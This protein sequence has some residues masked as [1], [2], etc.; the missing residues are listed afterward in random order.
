MATAL[1]NLVGSALQPVLKLANATKITGKTPLGK[2]V[3]PVPQ[4]PHAAS[5]KQEVDS[6]LDTL[7]ANKHNW[8]QVDVS[9]RAEL[10]SACLKNVLALA[11]E[12]A[13]V[14]TVAKGSYEGG[15]G[16][17]M[18]TIL[19]IVTALLEYRET[20]KANGCKPPLKL[21]RRDDGQWVARVWPLNMVPV[22]FPNFVGEVWIQPG[23]EPTQGALY[24]AKQQGALGEG[25]VALVLG[26]GNQLPVVALDILH[27][28]LAEDHVVLCKMNPVNDYYGPLLK[29]AFLPLA[30]RGFLDFVYGGA[31]V[32]AY[33][34]QHPLV[35]SVH[36]TGSETTFNNIV[37]GTPEWSEADLNYHACNVASGLA[38][39]AGHN[40]I[41]A[42]VV[43]TDASWPQRRAFLQAV[44]RC[45]ADLQCRAPWYPGSAARLAEFKRQFPQAQSL[46]ITVPSAD[47]PPGHV[48]AQPW[49]IVTGLAPEEAQLRHE[50]WA[51]VL[52]EIALPNCS[53]T[54][55][56]IQKSVEFANSKCWGSLAVSMFIHPRTQQQHAQAYEAALANLQYGTIC[57]N[58]P[59]TVGFS[60]TPLV[61]GA[62]PGNTAQDIGSG[63]GI[64][65]NTYLFDWPQKS[66]L[67]APWTYNPQPLWSVG[68]TGLA[69]ALPHAFRFLANQ[70]KPLVALL[71]LT[72]VAWHALRGSWA[73]GSTRS[74]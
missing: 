72:A 29:Q 70:D 44:V 11:P 60:A 37:F 55:A 3:L 4:K 16:D 27:M 18:V 74:H 62:F 30:S 23:Q 43:I 67:A 40:C 21:H 65:H 58:C 17:D 39:N 7:Q 61:W 63:S 59:T 48:P 15:S 51:G 33:C 42:E 54:D 45:L 19:P 49:L 8:V 26:A 36:L 12:L 25:G 64:V 52:Q 66:V 14:G 20:M 24:R 69:M 56:F 68:Q 50:N 71:H 6:I 47:Q 1:W 2:P 13:R 34:C 57:V 73:V 35:D 9:E 46:G 5:S 10:L 41:A 32:G 31:D 53:G 22:F 38:Q 28:M